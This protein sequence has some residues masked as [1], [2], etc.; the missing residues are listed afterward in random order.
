MTQFSTSSKLTIAN[1]DIHLWMTHPEKIQ[2]PELLQRYHT[3]LD[4]DEKQKQQAYKFTN[5]RHDA[6]ITRAFV[7]D[8]LS[9]YDDILPQA[10]LF[11]KGEYGKPEIRHNKKMLRF[12]LSHTKKLIICAVTLIDDIGCDVE[13]LNRTN[14]ILSIASRYFAPNE[15]KTLLALDPSL[16]RQAF[17]NYWT[18]KESYIKACGLGLSIPLKNFNFTI[19]QANQSTTVADDNSLEINSNIVVNFVSDYQDQPEFWRSWLL[20]PKSD[21]TIAISTKATSNNQ[22]KKY[23][24]RCFNSVP[25]VGYQELTLASE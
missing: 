3:L 12:N 18:L 22:D 2:A 8:L 20:Y 9:Y 21:H 23:Q 7:R 19:N 11:D 13:T 17:F 15:A 5:D 24:L 6:L 1:D 4:A 16:Q 10:W 14:D 25:L